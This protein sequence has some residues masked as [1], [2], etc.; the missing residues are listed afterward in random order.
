MSRDNNYYSYS[1]FEPLDFELITF[2]YHLSIPYTLSTIPYIPSSVD[3]LTYFSN[4]RLP[5]QGA[6]RPKIVVP[7]DMPQYV[8]WEAW[9]SL[10]HIGISFGYAYSPYQGTFW[11]ISFTGGES[12]IIG[13]SV[14]EGYS[15][16]HR[17]IAFIGQSGGGV[18]G[19]GG[20]YLNPHL[21]RSERFFREEGGYFGYEASIGIMI[22]WG[23]R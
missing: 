14:T 23:G 13:S 12:S 4:R 6:P 9:I 10:K 2:N 17:G 19:Q 15:P 1:T 7:A 8:D 20:I 22:M 18:G 16:L 5:P 3:P 11:H 21:K